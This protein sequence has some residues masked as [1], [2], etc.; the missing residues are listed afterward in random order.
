MP[1]RSP[2]IFWLLLAATLC[3]DVVAIGL[4]FGR[5]LTPD[6]ATIFLALAYGQLSILSVRVVLAAGKTRVRW[7]VPFVVGAV[8]AYVLNSGEPHATREDKFQNLLA[9]V[10]LMW[11]HV[12]TVLLILWLLRP[13]KLCESFT[14]RAE[15]R[16]WQFSTMQ[17]L[18]LTTS[19]AVL[20]V[21]LRHAGVLADHIGLVVS[22]SINNLALL[23]LVMLVVSKESLPGFIR[24]AW[25]LLFALL[26]AALCVWFAET[27]AREIRPWVFSI[28]QAITLWAW[29]EQMR[30]SPPTD[31]GADGGEPPQ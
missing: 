31:A 13:S 26:V 4:I 21:L 5:P 24:L 23:L 9:F 20:L 3:V 28:V 2:I 25:S 16:R 14:D 12:A 30:C 22:L 11:I 19:L 8:A 6:R 27:L 15:Q 29:L 18:V 7:F 17:L 10:G 1:P